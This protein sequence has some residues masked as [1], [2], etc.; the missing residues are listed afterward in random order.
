MTGCEPECV[1]LWAQYQ[2]K[3][4]TRTSREE[5]AKTEGDLVKLVDIL[6]EAIEEKGKIDTLLASNER[7]N[8]MI[9][10]AQKSK[11]AVVTNDCVQRFKDTVSSINKKKLA[12]S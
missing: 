8:Q 5:E 3:L 9:N 7:L 11:D 1:S 4:K 10:N 12:N 2:E 6:Q